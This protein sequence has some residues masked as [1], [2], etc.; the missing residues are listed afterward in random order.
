MPPA[1]RR[2]REGIEMATTVELVRP[3]PPEPVAIA[4]G[5]LFI[6]GAWRDAAGG[7]TMPTVNPTTEETIT[8]IASGGAEDASAAA[9]AAHEA[10]ETGPWGRMRG[11]ERAKILRR[12]G[13]LI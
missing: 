13:D 3:A 6:A 2:D 4:P 1:R 11:S 9:A 5:R 8:E 7:R 12:I 10:F